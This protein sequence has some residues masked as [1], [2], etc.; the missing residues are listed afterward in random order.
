MP[1]AFVTGHGMS[2]PHQRRGS[3]PLFR[4]FLTL[5][6]Y[7]PGHNRRGGGCLKPTWYVRRVVLMGPERRCRCFRPSAEGTCRRSRTRDGVIGPYLD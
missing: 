6:V 2:I 5:C 3:W 1:R 4:Q 7:C